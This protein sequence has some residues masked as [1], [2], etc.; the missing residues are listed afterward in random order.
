VKVLL[1]GSGGREHAL[2]TQLVRSPQ[3]THLYV[4]PGNGG[5]ATLEKTENVAIPATKLDA[6][7]DFAQANR[8]DL[9]VVGPEAPLVA[10]IVDLFQ[11][12]GLRIFGP[13]QA[14]ARLEG[15]K[16]F[17]KQ[18]ML[19]HGIPTGQ[20]EIF[21]DY[22]EAVRY[23]R[24]LDSPPVIKA[25]GLAAGKGVLVPL[26]LE[27]AALALRTMLLD[28]RFGEAG[29]TV[30]IEER[31]SGPELSVLAFCDGKTA[32]ILPPAQDYKRLR[33]GDL[34]PNTGGMGAYTP[35]P[36]ATPGLLAQV[37]REIL[38]PALNGMAAEG[39]PYCGVLYAGLMLTRDGPK[40]IEFNAR[41][42]DP[43]TQAVLPLLE[44]DLIDLLLATLEGNLASVQPQWRNQAAVTVVMAA[45]GYPDQYAT[46]HEITHIDRA[47][48]MGCLVFHAG[49]KLH[50][51][52]LLTAGGRVLNVTGLG[53]TVAAAAKNAYA[54]V[55]A[56]H[57]NQAHYRT[58]IGK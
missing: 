54:G 27:E 5:A 17:S 16:A 28:R 15:S 39:A 13:S 47:E 24:F 40:V 29:D 3:V 4:A 22:D 11:T 10:G 12:A 7:R 8:I 9:T 26:S 50:N 36:L 55:R 42:G 14:A 23:L 48:A 34:G 41:L 30:L 31:L 18:F 52:R 53:D 57:F 21:N 51:G 6:L 35:S 37:E 25:S 2:A 49:T 20:A 1:I 56:I 44:S 38:Q 45:G 43:E 32:T 58:D 33:N 46:G 19:R